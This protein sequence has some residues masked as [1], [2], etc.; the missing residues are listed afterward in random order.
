MVVQTLAPVI[1][2][3][4][5]PMMTAA[6]NMHKVAATAMATPQGTTATVIT[7]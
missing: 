6:V 1:M 7:M 3:P 4:M 5:P 2:T